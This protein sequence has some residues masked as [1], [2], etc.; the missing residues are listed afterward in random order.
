MD[1]N[2]IKNKVIDWLTFEPIE[3]YDLSSPALTRLTGKIKDLVKF[4]KKLFKN[5]NY[6]FEH[7]NQKGIAVKF[8]EPN[9]NHKVKAHVGKEEV[10]LSFTGKRDKSVK[11]I[12]KLYH[13]GM[14]PTFEVYS[15]DIDHNAYELD[16][17]IINAFNYKFKNIS[18]YVGATVIITKPKIYFDYFSNTFKMKFTLLDF[19]LPAAQTEEIKPIDFSKIIREKIISSKI[20]EYTSS[21]SLQVS[22]EKSEEDTLKSGLKAVENLEYDHFE[23][24]GATTHPKEFKADNWCRRIETMTEELSQPICGAVEQ[25]IEEI[26]NISVD[27]I[28]IVSK[29]ST[30]A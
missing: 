4:K 6:I 23:V 2:K 22:N 30:Y 10:C 8:A 27:D 26:E 5:A 24:K 21:L 25:P 14:K 15:P 11:I 19:I 3:K 16:K 12:N 18:R 20:K 28:Y 7:L 9:E 29:S 17:T 13:I 1:S